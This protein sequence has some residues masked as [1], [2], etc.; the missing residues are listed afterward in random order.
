M[1]ICINSV[2]F[3]I[4]PNKFGLAH[5]F[6]VLYQDILEIRSYL[7]DRNLMQYGAELE[8]S[9][10]SLPE[11][12]NFSSGDLAS[13]FG[14]KR[15]H[16]AR[17]MN[18][19][20]PCKD[21]LPK[22]YDAQYQAKQSNMPSRNSSIPKNFASSSLQKMESANKLIVRNILGKDKSIEQSLSNFKIRDGYT[23]KGIV[24]TK[25]ADSR[26]CGCIKPPPIVDKLAPY[27][28]IEN[29][30][31]QKLAPEYKIGMDHLVK[32]KAPPMKASE[33]WRDK[34]AVLI[35]IRRPG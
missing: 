18:K 11:L 28:S 7:H 3:I 21:P 19:T 10:K 6:F 4:F 9:G 22:P 34:P 29:I 2:I 12:L 1:I 8:N 32:S 20:N 25:P 27:S 16:I 26:G 31:V 35:C 5:F 17:F 15:G 23:F 30:S 24:A 13:Q 14:M 33:L